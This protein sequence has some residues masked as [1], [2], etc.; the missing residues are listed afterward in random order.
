[1]IYISHNGA[2]SALVR[3]QVLPYLEGLADRGFDI[4]L[5]TFERDGIPTWRPAEGVHWH[6]LRSR[7]GPSIV[8]KGL[9]IAVGTFSV[10]RSTLARRTAFLHARSYVAAA[11][12][13]V[14]G[15]V[16]RRPYVFDM[17]G[18]LAEEF[19][20]AGYWSR[21]DVRYRTLRLVEPVLLRRAAEIVVLTQLAAERLRHDPDYAAARNASITVIP[22]AVDLRRFAVTPATKEW[23]LVYSGSLGSFYELDAMLRVFQAAL[24]I[25]P[26]SR[27]LILNQRDH[28][29]IRST[30]ER[31]GVPTDALTILSARPDEMPG[32]LARV[33]VGIALIKQAPS[34]AASS[35]IKV[36]E[37]LACGLPVVVNFGL[38]DVAQQVVE[39]AAGHV[40]RDYSPA[41]IE[42][43]G[44]AV[45]ALAD[46]PDARDRARGLAVSE[47]DLVAATEKYA[48]IYRR[49]AQGH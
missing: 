35:A 38:G 9:D 7:S 39:S 44:R 18:F 19:L 11:V 48:A 34:K 33:C 5:F 26:S 29:L 32:H 2:G 3:S 20:E 30:A 14:V 23:L 12:A 42:E 24:A 22:C 8:D 31:L 15:A 40:M 36:A 10:L 28:D 27:M 37:Y 21:G 6:P 25:R 41:A 1:V 17:R 49:L 47:Y 43:A 13:V 45:V 4:D 46:S 16:A